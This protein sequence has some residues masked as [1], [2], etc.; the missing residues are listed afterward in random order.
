MIKVLKFGG[1]SIRDSKR[2]K[3]VTKIIKDYNANKVV[4]VFSAI[5]NIT[6]LLEELVELHFND[7]EKK[8]EKLSEVKKIHFEI[9]NDL[10]T[11]N[12]KVFSEIEIVFNE[13]SEILLVKNNYLFSKLYD[14]IVS[15]GELLSSIILSNYLFVNGLKNFLYDAREII[16]TDSK[17]QNAKLIGRQ[18]KKM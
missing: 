5:A 14:K 16:K 18:L 3:N 13:I 7:D 9:M 4:I 11:I 17:F 6:N 10:F 1:A 2:I 8:T 15:K 12:H